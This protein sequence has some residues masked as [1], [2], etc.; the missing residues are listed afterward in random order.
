MVVGSNQLILKPI[1]NLLISFLRHYLSKSGT[2]YLLK[3]NSV[4]EVKW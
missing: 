4:L 2:M 3:G 1:P